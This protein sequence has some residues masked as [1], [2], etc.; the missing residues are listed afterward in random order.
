MLK[1][2]RELNKIIR[3]LKRQSLAQGLKVYLVGGFVRDLI[4]EVKNLDLDVLVEGDGIEFARRFSGLL[5]GSSIV[6]HK[7]FGTATLITEEKLKIDFSSS[8]KEFYPK[9]AHLPVVSSGSLRDDLLRRD[10]TIN[11]MAVDLNS[12]LLIDFF[13][14]RSDIKQKKIRVLHN[15]S[16]CDDPLRIFRA[17]RFEQRYNFKIEPKTLKLIK[18]SCRARMLEKVHPHRIRDDLVI[19]LKEKYPIK[20]ILR[21]KNLTGFRFIDSSLRVNAETVSFLK[22]LEQKINWFKENFPQRRE[23]DSWLIYLI[24]LLD[25][26]KSRDIQAFCAR[27]GMRRGDEKRIISF[28]TFPRS[29]AKELSSV[30]VKPSKIF[31]A[32]EGLSYETII[33]LLAAS[34]NRIFERNVADFLEIYNGMRILV[35]GSDLHGLGLKP[36]PQYQKIFEQVLTA[37]LDG[38]V[39]SRQDEI[40]L[41][42]KM[43]NKRSSSHG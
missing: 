6:I 36:G 26:L 31:E 20:S 2:P 5:K 4:L 25:S 22:I 21:L 17:V 40:N 34:K 43:L 29:L 10:F 41:I 37:K 38:K 3:E 11:A 12:G 23:L 33:S 24:G 30:S 28:K 35:S 39:N 18:D 42:R 9:P 13:G 1:F 14:G 32:L 7:R 8:R 15:L 27:F 16:F 19:M